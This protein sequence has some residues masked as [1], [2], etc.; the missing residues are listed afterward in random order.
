M[1]RSMLTVLALT[2]AAL[3]IP[4]PP[5]Q[6]APAQAAPARVAPATTN[7][8]SG[9]ITD[10]ATGEPI[11]GACV[12]ASNSRWQTRARVCA[13][14]DGTYRIDGLYQ[15]AVVYLRATVDT[16]TWWWP[17]S[18]DPV[19]ATP[20]SAGYPA[21]NPVADFA[22][23][24]RQ[25]TVQGSVTRQDGAPAIFASAILYRVGA[26]KPIAFA[27][28]FDGTFRRTG[29]PVGQYHIVLGG[30][31]YNTQWYPA[32]ATRA[33]ATPVEITEG[34]TVPIAEQFRAVEPIPAVPALVTVQGVVTAAPDGAPVADAE[35]SLYSHRLDPFAT[36]R[37][38]AQGRFAFP[39]IRKDIGVHVKVSA[40]GFAT[41][42]NPDD[43]EPYAAV[44][45]SETPLAI[46][47]RPGSGR[48]TA[49]LKDH[50]GTTAPTGF[51]ATLSSQD[52]S[53]SH[54]LPVRLDGTIDL[55]DVPAGQYRLQLVDSVPATT[56]RPDQWYPS[57][58]DSTDAGLITI[59]D[60]QTTAITESLLHPI[61][62]EVTVRD[63]R[64]GAQIS[65]ACVTFVQE[66]CTAADADGLYRTVLDYRVY[67][68]YVKATHAPYHFMARTPVIPRAGEIT[69]VTVTMEPGA[70]IATTYRDGAVNPDPEGLGSVCAYLIQGRWGMDKL[71]GVQVCAMPAADGTLRFGPLPSGWVQLFVLP[72]G[73]AGAQWL[74]YQGGTGD[75]RN[76]A[77]IN[78]K[79]GV[80]T[81]APDI[82]PARAG[83][84]RGVVRNTVTGAPVK[85]CVE[86][87]PRVRACAE[88]A[89]TGPML[90]GL[91]PYHWPLSYSGDGFPPTQMTVKAVS[92]QTVFKDA[93]VTPGTLVQSVQFGG[94]TA[95]KSWQVE[96][97]DAWTGALL[98]T[99]TF[100]GPLLLPSTKPVAIRMTHDGQRCWAHFTEGRRLTPYY[101]AGSTAIAK[102]TLTPGT[103][104][105][106]GEPPLLP[107]PVRGAKG[108]MVV[109]MF[110]PLPTVRGGNATGTG[111]GVAPSTAGTTVTSPW[112]RPS[113]GMMARVKP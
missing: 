92:G 28:A 97:F 48:F 38:D 67:T 15:N 49:V 53:W 18:M 80:V 54:T 27:T 110:D 76:A 61:T 46:K 35:V 52:G 9:K 94:P 63:A 19:Y 96:A 87:G 84:V 65:D 102:L 24:R 23:E 95:P 109:T 83:V 2:A 85:A 106:P 10:A 22:I 41:T 86:A 50:D 112:G 37:T 77:L 108:P 98:S 3:I 68:Y 13:G 25:G 74:G 16:T 17:G 29:V 31:G 56:P 90:Y 51:T 60:G 66:V 39:N 113:V 40:P 14:A 104:C 34:G 6:G 42:W 79:A 26:D 58:P 33:E 82:V 4:S 70:V 8:I 99:S 45:A 44:A 81:R 78:L 107:A 47:L 11:A 64:T 75:R 20:V 7:H 5:A 100:N 91:G 111:T 30:S 12:T 71:G 89:E 101:T 55:A 72:R 36:T 69:K 59:T 88:H 43:P 73:E 103:N 1:R 21:T 93:Q 105:L 57:R 32:A 62:F